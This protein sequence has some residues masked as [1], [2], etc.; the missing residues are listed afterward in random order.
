MDPLSNGIYCHAYIEEYYNRYIEPGAGPAS[1]PAADQDEIFQQ[2]LRRADPMTELQPVLGVDDVPFTTEQM[3][4]IHECMR[5]HLE[6]F[7]RFANEKK[8]KPWRMEYEMGNRR[9]DALF[10]HSKKNPNE[11]H[12]DLY[13]W[14]TC[15]SANEHGQ[16]IENGMNQLSE[17]QELLQN[18]G[19]TI[20]S[21]Y[22]VIFHPN[23]YREIP[24]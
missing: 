8:L 15:A 22:I 3:R 11:N 2:L 17:Y 12:L 16:H 23:G 13:D 20:H 24:F 14:K 1:M 5:N 21:R 4:P 7:Y 19:R 9:C 18:E 10:Y 6:H